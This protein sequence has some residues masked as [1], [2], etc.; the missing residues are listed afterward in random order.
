MSNHKTLFH[1]RL[2]YSQYGQRQMAIGSQ[3]TTPSSNWETSTCLALLSSAL[4]LGCG[5][6]ETPMWI[7]W[8]W[9]PYLFFPSRLE[10]ALTSSCSIQDLFNL[11]PPRLCAFDFDSYTNKPSAS[12]AYKSSV[13]YKYQL[14]FR[15]AKYNA[16]FCFV[17]F[18]FVLF[19]DMRLF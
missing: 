13:K 7:I 11:L 6:K 1:C 10:T 4:L 16:C 2:V 12:Y 17:L 3:L 5:G 19:F 8:Q 9:L 15:N 14:F 18:F